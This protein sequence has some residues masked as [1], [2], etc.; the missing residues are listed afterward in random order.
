MPALPCPASPCPPAGF[1]TQFQGY[2]V[3]FSPFEE[4]RLAVATSQNFGII[5]NGRQYVLQVG[6]GST[7]STGRT[8]STSCA[9]ALWVIGSACCG[10]VWDGS[11]LRLQC[12]CCRCTA[13]ARLR[14]PQLATPR[15]QRRLHAGQRVLDTRCP[16]LFPAAPASH[17]PPL[18]PACL[19]M[20]PGGIVEQRVFDTQDGLYD[21][22]WSEEN[23][24]ILVSASGDGSIKVRRRQRGC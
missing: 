5:G 15:S 7:D 18:P 8:G 22:A 16:L 17:R 1:H 6:W 4:S 20:G 14:Q 9:A 11:G 23:E 2:S 3:R 19:Q 24:N 21:C 10:G 12:A 13:I